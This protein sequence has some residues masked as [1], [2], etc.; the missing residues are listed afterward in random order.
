MRAV[1][2]IVLLL[3]MAALVSYEIENRRLKAQCLAAE[4]RP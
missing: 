4:V 1:F 2:L 3:N